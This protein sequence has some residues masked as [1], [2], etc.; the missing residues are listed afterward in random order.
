MMLISLFYYDKSMNEII[1]ILKRSKIKIRRENVV[2]RCAT[3]IEKG[4]AVCNDSVTVN[5]EPLKVVLSNILCDGCYDE[6]VVKEYVYCIKAFEDRQEIFD[7][8]GNM[9]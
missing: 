6:E 3:M 5:E 8:N 4:K 1:Y 2:W 7:K 9:I